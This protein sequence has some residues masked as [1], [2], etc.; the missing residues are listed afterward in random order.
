MSISY[1]EYIEGFNNELIS[2]RIRTILYALDLKARIAIFTV[3]LF[4]CAMWALAHDLTGE[5]GDDFKDVLAAQQFYTVEHIAGSLD[6]AVKLRINALADAATL[7]NS[8]WMAHPDLLHGFMAK[9]MPLQRFFNTGL[10]VISREGIGLADLPH[11]EGREGISY[12]ERDYFREVMATGK[13]VVGK[14]ILGR[15]T[16]K[17]TI[18]IAVPIKS[19][20][21]EVIG[22]LVGGNQFVESDFLNEI[23]PAKLNMKEDLHVI[24]P[25]DD[26]FV[27]S[28]SHD[29]ILQAEPA[30]NVIKMY[31]RY[32]QGYEG[33]GVSAN[34]KG[35]E[36]LSSGKRVPSTGWLVIATLPTSIA[37]AP[38]A[39]V[40]REIYQDTAIASV[41]IALLLWLF[42]QRQ[43]SPLSRSAQIIN[44]M[45]GGHEPLR[46][47]PLDGSKEI[48]RLLDS[49]NK[50]QLHIGEQADSL[51]EGAEQ[52][53][54]AA[55]VFEGTSEA[56]LISSADNHII[57]V[58]RAFCRMTGYEESELIGRTPNVLKSGRHD[59]IFY[60]EM[61]SSLLVTGQWQGEI[62][63]RRKSGEIYPER[64]T[65]STLYDKEGK[66]LRYIAIAAD[67]T[68]QKQAEAVIWQQAN[69]DLLTNLPNRRLLQDMMQE[70][71]EKSRR[72]GLS[73][74]V[75]HADLDRFKEVNGALGHGVGDQMI[76]EVGRRIVSCMET[77][78]DAVAHLGG[79][80][81]VVVLSALADPLPHVEEMAEKILRAI[82]EPFR[83]GSETIYISTSIGI[84]RYPADCEDVSSMLKKSEQA[85]HAAKI[86]GRN[87]YCYFT[88]A[89]ERAAQ[90][91]K[92]LANDMHGAL[93][94]R[95]FE[96]YYQ[97]ILNLVTGEIVKAE[98]LLRWH[99]PER[100]MV[101]PMEFIPI[102]EENGLIGEIGDWVFKEA[103]QMAKRWC[104]YCGLSVNGACAK[105]T[106]I[107]GGV[108]S[109]VYQV[110]VNKS[111]RQFFTRD[112]DKTWID[113]LRENNID[114][115]CITI[116]ITEG[117]L[118]DQHPE[119]TQKFMVFRDAGIQI[120]LDDF[121]TGYS[122]MAYLKQFD[123]DY[124]KIDRSFVRDIITDPSD[125]A[126]AEAIIA[127]AHKLGLKV[128]AEG[129]E[130]IEQ[131]DLLAEAGCDYGQGYLFAKPMPAAQFESLIN[132][133]NLPRVIRVLA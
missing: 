100:G 31:D 17:P 98:A 85:K 43:L 127:M 66:V 94:A 75:L 71:L 128:V 44:A 92:Q 50:L 91:R 72:E 87:R 5:I 21:N 7:I 52:M 40:Q 22:V 111:P 63:N 101:S 15:L 49:F 35:I 132:N 29:L 73:F 133:A 97:P 33:S 38:I 3:A 124:L 121:G 45:A 48:R 51:R 107:D 41:I 18:S 86:E 36:N 69:Y 115:R 10:L 99:H 16:Y 20:G 82:A 37:F 106:A 39:A 30:P 78:A 114:P 47:L 103:A 61:W 60:Q 28:T 1:F 65:I 104:G 81:F 70:A 19:S 23:V 55:S 76:I 59:R 11:L 4:S 125:R 32:K 84:V 12:I 96:V 126:I 123:I 8:D 6:E 112:T 102:A 62:W 77:D 14:P 95:Q 119:V 90:T 68:K 88:A 108:A 56:I 110:T 118:L 13:P 83:L 24:S 120:A 2:M 109:C 122:A 130:T 117:L 54:L 64:L 131:R 27:T 9:S 105:A 79:D 58:N 42:L 89:M 67:I 53:R 34:S 129:V 93:A 116:E 74:A 80:E 57:S 26:A 113:Y 46:P 25:K